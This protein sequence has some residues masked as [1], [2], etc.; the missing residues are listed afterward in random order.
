MVK[1]Q[2]KNLYYYL[3]YSIESILKEFV[4]YEMN[5]RNRQ[6]LNI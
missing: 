3:V 6:A 1:N 2:Y 4:W 5:D